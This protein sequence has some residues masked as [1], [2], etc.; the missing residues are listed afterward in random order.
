MLPF[1]LILVVLF[2]SENLWTGTLVLA[3]LGVASAEED[4]LQEFND[5]CAKTEDSMIL[6]SNELRDLIARCDTLKP[7]V[8]KLPE[9]QKK[10]YLKRLQSCR[11]LYVFTLESKSDK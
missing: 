7:L 5:V 8:E 11:D 10:V 4:W 2:S 3:Q 9:T 1:V 6:S